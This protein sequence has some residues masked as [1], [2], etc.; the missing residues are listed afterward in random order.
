MIKWVVTCCLGGDKLHAP[1]WIMVVSVKQLRYSIT[2][3]RSP[4]HWLVGRKTHRHKG[5]FQKLSCLPSSFRL[6]EAALVLWKHEDVEPLPVT[7]QNSISHYWL[8]WLFHFDDK[9]PCTQVVVPERDF[10]PHKS[11]TEG[12]CG[13]RT[14]MEAFIIMC[15]RPSLLK[16]T[17]MLNWWDSLEMTPLW[18]RWGTCKLQSHQGETHGKNK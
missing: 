1:N 10:F 16:L 4:L 18:H 7:P 6:A 3:S 8:S 11:L 14:N 13:C 12:D 2:M 5:N 17:K 15:P 9:K